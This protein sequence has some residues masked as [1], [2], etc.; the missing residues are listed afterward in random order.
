MRLEQYLTEKTFNINKDVEYIYNRCFKGLVD[1]IHKQT[2][3]DVNFDSDAIMRLVNGKYDWF[4]RRVQKNEIWIEYEQLL[5]EDLP[6][7]SAKEASKVN[8][9]VIFCGVFKKGNYYVPQESAKQTTKGIDRSIISLS[10]NPSALHFAL[11]G[12]IKEPAAQAMEV[13][14]QMK[15]FR[16]EFKP[17]RIKA[18]I[19]HELSHWMN[20]T[21]HNYHITN[22]LKLARELSDLEINK[23]GKKDVNMTHFEIDAQIHGIKQLKRSISK[24]WNELE[25]KDV[26]F[27]YNSLRHMGTVIYKGHG[28]EIGDIWQKLLIKRMSREKLLG[29]N[30]RK[31]AKYPQDFENY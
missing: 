23:L 26:L 20:D 5:S 30:M 25:I 15:S 13:S 3:K 10:L 21:F 17:Q 6:S 9:T 1:E 29:K 14:G 31:F 18:T 19:A 24:I 7:K 8:P 28:K 4:F 16:Q 27:R 22:M 2:G 12:G 11:T